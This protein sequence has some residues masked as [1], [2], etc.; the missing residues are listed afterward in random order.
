MPT[1]STSTA[2]Y[3]DMVFTTTG[4]TANGAMTT[5]ADPTTYYASVAAGIDKGANWTWDKSG[6]TGYTT[7]LHQYLPSVGVVP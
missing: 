2:D 5:I 6:S 1:T 3:Q 7:T 4:L